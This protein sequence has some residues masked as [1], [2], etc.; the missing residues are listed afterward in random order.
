MMQKRVTATTEQKRWEEL[1]K[2]RSLPISIA[3]KRAMKAKLAV[4]VSHNLLRD[5]MQKWIL[6]IN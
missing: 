4:S 2:I 5:E 1:N 3:E 6:L